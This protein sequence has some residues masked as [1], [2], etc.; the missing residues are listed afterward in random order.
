M[1]SRLAIIAATLIWS[2]SGWTQASE[3]K[4]TGKWRGEFTIRDG[5]KAP[6]NFEIRNDQK[7][8]L[9]NGEEVFETARIV[10]K[11]DSLFVPLDQFDNELAFKINN[12]TLRGVLRRQDHTG[13]TTPVIAEKGIQYRFK[14]NQTPAGDIGGSYDVEFQFE[15]GKKEKGVAVFKQQGNKLT[16]TFL[17]PSG[18]TRF[19]EGV[20]HGNRFYLS[21]FIGSSPGYYEGTF[22]T[23]GKIRGVQIGTRVKH[24]FNGSRNENAA[25]NDPY[26]ISSL[27]KGQQSLTFSFPDAEGKIVSLSDEKYKNKVVIV[28]ITGTWCPNCIDEAAFLSPWYKKNKDRGVEVITIHYERQTDTAFAYKMMRRFRKRF[29]IQYD[30]VLGGMAHTDS[31]SK[32]LPQLESFSSF[33]T[34]IFIDKKG[35]V[36]KIHTG[37]TGPATGKFYDEFVKEFNEEVD[38]LLER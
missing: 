10:V 30:Q 36:S 17:K 14:Q 25:L 37:Y 3:Q 1:N 24:E 23:D 11:D 21:S 29:D 5:T 20:V 15:S 26:K 22:S 35:N 8:Y 7:L 13:N 12:H 31:V 32:S 9:I 28:A 27:K 19:L 38:R 16:G 33:P 6:F 34:T 2:T 18:D 4:L